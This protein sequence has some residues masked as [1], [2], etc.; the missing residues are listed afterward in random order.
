ML[1]ASQIPEQQVFVQAG[2]QVGQLVSHPAIQL[3]GQEVLLVEA[4][5]KQHQQHEVVLLMQD[6]SLSEP[7]SSTPVCRPPFLRQ[8]TF[9]IGNNQV[10]H[11]T[12]GGGDHTTDL[13]E[14]SLP[15]WAGG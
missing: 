12:A 4:H 2:Q 1:P 3:A 15:N 13:Q 8:P 5:Y 11:T 7:V 9:V 10:M 6:L 14:H